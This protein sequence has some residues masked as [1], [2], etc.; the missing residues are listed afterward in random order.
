MASLYSEVRPPDYLC[1][2][3]PA[4]SVGSRA[5]FRGR[6]RVAIA[7]AGN[8]SRIGPIAATGSVP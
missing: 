4:G 8:V 6:I 7:I 1:L 2:F 5:S 3:L